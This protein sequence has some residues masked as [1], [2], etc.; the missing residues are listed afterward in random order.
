ML[1]MSNF[2]F[3]GPRLKVK[4]ILAIFRKKNIIKNKTNFVITLVP[5]FVDRIYYDFIQMLGMTIS[6]AGLTF[7][8]LG[9]RSRSLSL[10]LE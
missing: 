10:L 8:V 1:D 6:R 7:R 4:I 3:Q 5:T 9:S 2:I